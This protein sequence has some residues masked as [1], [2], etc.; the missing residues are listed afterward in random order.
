MCWVVPGCWDVGQS[1]SRPDTCAIK[2]WQFE[3][4]VMAIALFVKLRQ[5]K[6]QR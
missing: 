1:Q 5:R 2:D 3:V 4:A 6:R